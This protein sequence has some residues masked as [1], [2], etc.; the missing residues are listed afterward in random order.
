M[1]S[2]EP[3]SCASASL[4]DADYGVL[5]KIPTVIVFGDHLGDVQTT[6]WSN[7][8]KDCTAYVD[9]IRALGGDATLISL[10]A[11]GMK[12]NGHMFMQDRNSLAI[13]DL[14]LKWIDDHA[15]RRR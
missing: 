6:T 9:K 15:E 8:F 7:A 14:V 12:G 4:K 5:A 1:I 2:L 11:L 13:A 3:G 10:P